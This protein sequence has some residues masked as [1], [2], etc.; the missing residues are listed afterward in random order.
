MARTTSLW[1]GIWWVPWQVFP[2]SPWIISDKLTLCHSCTLQGNQAWSWTATKGSW[3]TVWAACTEESGSAKAAHTEDE[4]PQTAY[5]EGGAR[6][7]RGQSWYRR[8]QYLETLF[9]R[10]QRPHILR[11]T[12]TTPEPEHSLWS[13]KPCESFEVPPRRMPSPCRLTLQ[14]LKVQHTSC[15]LEC[16]RHD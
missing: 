10:N 5:E 11:N 6:A 1:W 4:I 14:P 3:V 7:K 8:S 13:A 2:L 16:P 9:G 12:C 15:P